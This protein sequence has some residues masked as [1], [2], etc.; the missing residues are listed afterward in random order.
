MCF[1]CSTYRRGDGVYP[2]EHASPVRFQINATRRLIYGLGGLAA[3]TNRV[4]NPR[5]PYQRRQSG[6][7]SR[8]QA[9]AQENCH[10]GGKQWNLAE[11]KV[12]RIVADLRTLFS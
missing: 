6:R 8:G 9:I 12:W 11:A 5:A 7:L 3:V 10:R 4:A 1:R 2:F